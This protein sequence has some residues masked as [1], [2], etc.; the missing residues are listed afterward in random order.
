[1][2]WEH[3]EAVVWPSSLHAN[4]AR[5]SPAS[6]PPHAWPRLPGRAVL[7]PISGSGTYSLCP[8]RITASRSPP[9]EPPK[10][11]CVLPV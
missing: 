2:P 6:M 4:A 11:S 1:M 10:S 8:L 3:I 7:K 9:V 5:E